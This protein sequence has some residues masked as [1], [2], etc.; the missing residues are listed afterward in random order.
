MSDDART[1]KDGALLA[2]ALLDEIVEALNATHAQSAALLQAVR[3]QLAVARSE[4]ENDSP[5]PARWLVENALRLA[6]AGGRAKKGIDLE[7]RRH[8]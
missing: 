7:D 2:L 5:M 3:Q 6:F 8:R 1:S 4:I